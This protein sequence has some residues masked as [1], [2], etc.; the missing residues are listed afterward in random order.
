MRCQPYH[1]NVRSPDVNWQSNRSQIKKKHSTVNNQADGDWLHVR[2]SPDAP[3]P[4]FAASQSVS[5]QFLHVRGFRRDTLSCLRLA[6]RGFRTDTLSCPRLGLFRRI[7]LK[8][9]EEG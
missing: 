4:G 2:L 6:L 5:L 8:L 1:N 7:V 3:F 9:S